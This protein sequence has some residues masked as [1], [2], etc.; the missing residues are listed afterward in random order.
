MHLHWVLLGFGDNRKNTLKDMAIA[1]GA[2]VFGEEALEM[3]LEDVQLHDLGQVR[4]V[5][6][7]VLSSDVSGC[8][9]NQAKCSM[10]RRSERIIICQLVSI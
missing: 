8:L 10:L 6:T 9:P 2:L 7:S 5:I 1:T 3:K 4:L